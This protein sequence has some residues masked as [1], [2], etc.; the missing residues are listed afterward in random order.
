MSF[1]KINNTTTPTQDPQDPSTNILNVKQAVIDNLIKQITEG[2]FVSWPQAAGGVTSVYL[3]PSAPNFVIKNF[4]Y[5][6]LEKNFK[7]SEGIRDQITQQVKK[8]IATIGYSDCLVIPNYRLLVDNFY[9]EEQLPISSDTATN[10]G[11]YINHQKAFNRAISGLI[12]LSTIGRLEDIITVFPPRLGHILIRYDN[13]P[14]Y[15]DGEKGKVGLI[16]LERFNFKSK[17]NPAS[18]LDLVTI[19]PFHTEMIVKEAH[20]FKITLDRQDVDRAQKNGIT[21]LNKNYIDY[22]IH[23][24]K[25]PNI[26][27]IKQQDV[28]SLASKNISDSQNK[29]WPTGQWYDEM[30]ELSSKLN[31]QILFINYLVKY[32]NTQKS[33]CLKSIEGKS[34]VE[35]LI[36]G[37]K[38]SIT[39][40]RIIATM[41]CNARL[42]IRRSHDKNNSDYLNANEF[43]FFN[44]I[45][46]MYRLKS[47]LIIKFI[48]NVLDFLSEDGQLFHY[49]YINNSEES[50]FFF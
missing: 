2:K 12:Q 1:I 48:L 39:F 20:T 37:R 36:Q 13:I 7:P 49:E 24:R 18:I 21:Y 5:P 35:E 50:I 19:F 30:R 44:K 32:L 25:K 29:Q 8:A 11:L 10:M 14:L 43:I 47:D 42:E 23:I 15:L 22:E 41:S 45:D 3:P 38:I 28:N 6:Y 46:H 34:R 27:N 33:E 16:D 17:L 9:I 40:A 4:S 26:F 31:I